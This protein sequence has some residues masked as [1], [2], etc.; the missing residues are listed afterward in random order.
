MLHS[1]YSLRVPLHQTIRYETPCK[2]MRLSED[3]S[4]RERIDFEKAV[5]TS[6]YTEKNSQMYAYATILRCEG[7]DRARARRILRLVRSLLLRLAGLAV[8]T[9]LNPVRLNELLLLLYARFLS[10][11]QASPC[12]THLM[13]MCCFEA[14]HR[15]PTCGALF[16]L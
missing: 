14:S 3:R 5:D 10:A 6:A 2:S 4:H 15:Y 7:A 9:I 1:I 13:L 8:S 16:A 12:G 11:L